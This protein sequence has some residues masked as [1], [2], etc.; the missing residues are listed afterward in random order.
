[1]PCGPCVGAVCITKAKSLNHIFLLLSVK[2]LLRITQL[3]GISC[4]DDSTES[5][6]P[7]SQRVNVIY[8]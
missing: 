1:M 4:C 8:I 6:I 7:P 3:P 2:L 5:S